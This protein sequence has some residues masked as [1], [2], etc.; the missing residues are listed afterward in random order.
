MAVHVARG[1]LPLGRPVARGSEP[2]R[3]PATAVGLELAQLEPGHVDL[4]DRHAPPALLASGSAFLLRQVV[5]L[6]VLDEAV[7]GELAQVIARGAGRLAELVRE[8]GDTGPLA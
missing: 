2:V 4:V 8:A 1:L 3:E 5:G 6:E 7:A